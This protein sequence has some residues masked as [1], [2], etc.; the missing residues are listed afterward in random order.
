MTSK[1]LFLFKRSYQNNAT[2]KTWKGG[3]EKAGGNWAG[4]ASRIIPAESHLP[5][6][7]LSH[8]TKGSVINNILDLAESHETDG[9]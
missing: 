5:S 4:V 6:L 7:S 9:S 1:Q 3:A 2:I 8:P